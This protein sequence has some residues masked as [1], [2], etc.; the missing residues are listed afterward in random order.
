MIGVGEIATASARLAVLVMGTNDLVKELGAGHVPGREP[1][2]GPR[3]LR[4]SPP[5][6]PGVVI[7][8]GVYN[9]VK[10]PDGFEAE[11]APGA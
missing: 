2:L 7:L 4:C 10:D 9:D 8:D 11:C 3:S 1:L 5:G 6:A